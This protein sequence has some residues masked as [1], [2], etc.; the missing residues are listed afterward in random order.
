M[1]NVFV[2]FKQ[3]ET[4]K[5]GKLKK[6]SSLL[7]ALQLCEAKT[8]PLVGSAVPA[9]ASVTAIAGLPAIPALTTV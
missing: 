9:E 3:I 1:A 4:K 5:A 7:T 6:P 2:H 8:Y